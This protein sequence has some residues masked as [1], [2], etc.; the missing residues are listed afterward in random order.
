ME[1]GIVKLSI[2]IPILEEGEQLDR[3]LDSIRLQKDALTFVEVIVICKSNGMTDGKITNLSIGKS[4]AKIYYYDDTGEYDAMNYG[5]VLASGNYIQILCAGDEYYSCNTLENLMPH[6]NTKDIV[7]GDLIY[8]TAGGGRAI[9]Y[10]KSS[11]S[12]NDWK[13][14]KMIPHPSTFISKEF[15]KKVGFYNLDYD[16]IADYDLL[17]RALVKLKAV[18]KHVD[19]VIVRMDIGGRSYGGITGSL[20]QH[21]STFD[22]LKKLG[23]KP[24]IMYFPMK[25]FDRW[26]QYINALIFLK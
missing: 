20:G 6:L 19:Q 10:W 12:E 2:V 9:R 16:I 3:T 21:R 25:A 11:W 26:M 17:M 18:F 14:G 1:I 8:T 23:L 15:H 22:S 4:R 24:G 7:F 13:Y 5:I